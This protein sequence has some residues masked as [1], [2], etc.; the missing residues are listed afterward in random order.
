MRLRSTHRSGRA[1]RVE[2]LV[3]D[4]LLDVELA[5]G[6]HHL[7]EAID[8]ALGAVADLAHLAL[9]ALA[10]LA[11]HVALGTLGLELGQVALGSWPGRR[12]RRR[13]SSPSSTSR[14]DLGLER[15]QVA[16]ALLHVTW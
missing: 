6:V 14:R 3:T 10:H 15:R 8:L 7:V 4:Q 2:Q 12:C 13:A 1:A 5:E 16:V 9:A 11:P